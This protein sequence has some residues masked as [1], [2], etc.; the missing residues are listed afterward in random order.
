MKEYLQNIEEVLKDNQT[1]ESGLSTDE[2]QKRL[3]THGKNKLAKGK[4]LHGFASLFIR[5]YR[6]DGHYFNCSSGLFL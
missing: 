2:A 1:S 4:R 5:T 3:E 6:S